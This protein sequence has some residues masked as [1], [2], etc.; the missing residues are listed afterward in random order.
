MS[1]LPLNHITDKKDIFKFLK[2]VDFGEIQVVIVNCKPKFN[3]R[4]NGLAFGNKIETT[5]GTYD[6]N[7]VSLFENIENHMNGGMKVDKDYTL[8]NWT[9]QGVLLLNTALTGTSTKVDNTQWY[10]FVDYL[11]RFIDDCKSGV[12]F[13][14]I[15]DGGQDVWTSK[16]KSSTQVVLN[17]DK[18]DIDALEDINFEIDYLNG[19]DCR[20]KW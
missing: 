17:F 16:V 5:R 20:I 15:G 9:K 7:L 14:F 13:A 6:S 19:E 18:L 4:N 12:V 2:D 11:L 1:P 10:R 8:S 3:G